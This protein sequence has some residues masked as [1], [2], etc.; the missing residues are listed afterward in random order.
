[1]NEQMTI[2]DLLF[3]LN[4]GESMTPAQEYY[5]ITGKTTYW[6]DSQGKPYR[7]Y[8]KGELDHVRKGKM[9]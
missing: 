7:W 1:M 8:I 3:D 9:A 2:F 4:E 6:Q 5:M